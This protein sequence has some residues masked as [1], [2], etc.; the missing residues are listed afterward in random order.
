MRKPPVRHRVRQHTRRGRTVHSYERGHGKKK[1]TQKRYH[2]PHTKKVRIKKNN[3]HPTNQE[4]KP[5]D[6]WN[7]KP[8]ETKPFD[9]WSEE[10]PVEEEKIEE[11]EKTEEPEEIKP[12]VEEKKEI[13]L[14]SSDDL[15]KVFIGDTEEEA[16]VNAKELG[17]TFEKDELKA[18]EGERIL[19]FRYP[20]TSEAYREVDLIMDLETETVKEIETSESS[21]PG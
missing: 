15:E 3:P 10:K 5:F 19:H 8:H 20:I 17:F 9:F 18:D 11:E 7:A 12:P 16:R 13:P 2:N 6:F 4:S 14:Y 21:I 1:L